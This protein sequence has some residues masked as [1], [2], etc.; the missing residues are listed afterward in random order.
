MSVDV[1]M[2]REV[3]VAIGAL[4]DG[5]SVCQHR[6]LADDVAPDRRVDHVQPANER[7]AGANERSA[8]ASERSAGAS[9]RSAGA[10][11]RSPGASSRTSQGAACFRKMRQNSDLYRDFR[12]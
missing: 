12:L 5:A 2:G 11:E 4:V 7:S 3:L 1:R 6:R 10:N 9:E 8:G